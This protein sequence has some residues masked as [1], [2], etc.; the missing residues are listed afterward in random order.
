[1]TGTVRPLHAD[2]EVVLLR[3][4]QEAT[5]N[6]RWHA[7]SCRMALTLSY[8]DDVV[9]LDVRDDGVGM[10]VAGGE[11]N[12]DP[13]ARGYG[14]ASMRERVAG[15]GGNFSAESRPGEGTTISV[16]LPAAATALS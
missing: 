16:R 11:G 13:A 2:S 9:I 10:H 5:A 15:L 8:F 3:V 1:M 4:A 12:G 14:L 7:G 6:V